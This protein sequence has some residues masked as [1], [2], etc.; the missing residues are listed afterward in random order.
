MRKPAFPFSAVVGQER[1]KL[2]LILNAIDH[3]IGGVLLTGP[4]GSGKSTLV[5][6]AATLFPEVEVVQGCPYRCSPTDPA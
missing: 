3:N 6:A 5:R 4:K 1:A 2:G